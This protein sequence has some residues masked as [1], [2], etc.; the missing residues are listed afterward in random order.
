LSIF[1]IYNLFVPQLEYIYKIREK[2]DQLIYMNMH[3][4]EQQNDRWWE[5]KEKDDRKNFTVVCINT[6]LQV[7]PLERSVNKKKSPHI[8]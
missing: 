4:S 7:L 8:W 3:T 5:K 1:T 6:V 2:A